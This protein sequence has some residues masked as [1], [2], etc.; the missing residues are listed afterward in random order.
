MLQKEST[1][2][3]LQAVFAGKNNTP[4]STLQ[5]FWVTSTP[6]L[7]NDQDQIQE[8]KK[9]AAV[10]GPQSKNVWTVG[11]ALGA[12]NGVG[13]TAVFYAHHVESCLE[14]LMLK[15]SVCSVD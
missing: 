5:R 7:H 8:L 9:T 4:C 2:R 12:Q 10:T 14:L 15:L 6:E 11:Q 1:S 3:H 13:V